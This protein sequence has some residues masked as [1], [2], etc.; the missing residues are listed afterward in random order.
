MNIKEIIKELE[1][2]IRFREDLKEEYYAEGNGTDGYIMS[3][4]GRI[5]ALRF[6]IETIKKASKK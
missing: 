2:E 4:C 6:A 1:N 3:Q 5:D